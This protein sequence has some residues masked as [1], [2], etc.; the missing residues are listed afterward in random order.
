LRKSLKLLFI[1]LFA[2]SFFLIYFTP[3]GSASPDDIFLGSDLETRGNWIGKYGE[4][5]Y[6]L[7]FVDT[8]NIEVAT[9]K[10][11]GIGDPEDPAHEIW[12]MEP[13]SKPGEENYPYLDCLGGLNI[14]EYEV[15]GPVGAPRP[16]VNSEDDYYRPTWYEHSKSLE[17]NF[18]SITEGSYNVSLY[19]IDWDAPIGG[20]QMV[21]DVNVTVVDTITPSISYYKETIGNWYADNF[22]GGMYTVFQA[23]IPNSGILYI[24]VTKDA[25]S[26]NPNGARIS[27]IFLD[28]IDPVS[29][30]TGIERDVATKG[31]W[32]TTYGN[33]Y[34]LLPGFNVPTSNTP[35][36][37]IV[38]SYDQTNIDSDDYGVSK[39][40]IQFAAD[41]ARNYGEYP[42]IGQYSAYTWWDDGS[43]LGDYST[44]E[45]VL[46]WPSVC[47]FNG[48]PPPWEGNNYT[49]WD[50][51]EMNGVLNYFIINLTTSSPNYPLNFKNLT[52]YAYD[53]DFAGYPTQERSET[54]EIWNRDM[55]VLLDSRYISGDEI[56]NGIYLTWNVTGLDGVIIKVIADEGKLNSFINGIFADDCWC[57]DCSKT[58]AGSGVVPQENN[59]FKGPEIEVPIII[60]EFTTSISQLHTGPQV[61]WKIRYFIRNEYEY[62]YHF[63]MWD[64]WGGNLIA[65]SMQPTSV[66]L[67]SNGKNP[68]KIQHGSTLTMSNGEI[69]D[70]KDPFGPKSTYPQT[71]PQSQ[72]SHGT[73]KITAH[74]GDQQE[75]TNPGKGKG[76]KKDGNAYDFDVVWDIGVLQPGEFAYLDIY[77]VPG[78]NPAQVLE[79]SS[80]GSY[81]INTGPRFRV[82]DTNTP[83]D[84]LFAVDATNQLE[85][86]V[87]VSPE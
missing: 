71:V 10:N 2:L 19:F 67:V 13:W 44:D 56:L 35:Y 74:T 57:H 73:A 26:S 76:T 22:A 70:I 1:S 11:E 51:G 12:W 32:K 84:F 63:Q 42:F 6:A 23:N 30:V 59:D 18:T 39:G 54:I 37:P 61:Y 53:K 15:S 43:E 77:V 78:V 46:Q 79:F 45:G 86:I 25:G 17:V 3:V 36:T 60:D 68:N 75:G 31:N 83:Y 38:K 27:G 64:K 33:S 8:D 16:L 40:V 14:L 5:G 4:C 47:P 87:D 20:Q 24:N 80:P 28:L 58:F 52:I 41:D 81:L 21:L 49:A 72:V 66:Y 48:Y 9:G 50:S 82:Y 85:V 69:V 29:G 7:P 62:P 65:L 55:S 34:Y